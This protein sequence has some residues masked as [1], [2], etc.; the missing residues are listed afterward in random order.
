MRVSVVGGSTVTDTEAAA[1]VAYVER[2]LQ[3]E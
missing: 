3:G 1:A 2:E